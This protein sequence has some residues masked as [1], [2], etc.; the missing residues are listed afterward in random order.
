VSG[1]TRT[2]VRQRLAELR[3]ATDVGAVPEQGL[4]VAKLCRDWLARGLPGNLSENTR[5]QYRWA[6]ETHIVPALGAARVVNLTPQ[7]VD[8][9]LRTKAAAGKSRRTLTVLRMV[10]VRALRF[11]ERWGKVARNVAALV[12]IPDAPSK[13]GRSLTLEEAR[14]LLTAAASERL[15]A[16]WVTGLLVGLRPGE[17]LALGWDDVDLE[18]GTLQV[19]RALHRGADNRLYLGQVKTRT[20]RRALDLPAPVVEAMRAHRARQAVERLAAGAAWDDLGLV[21]CTE[22]GT[23]I[24]PSNLR[25]SLSKLTTRAGLGHWHPHEL[26]HSAASLLSAAGVPLED[27]ADL[28]GHSSPT[29]TAQVYRHPIRRTVAAGKLP[30]ERL[31]G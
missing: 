25:R 21:F 30:M 7:D 16:L 19:R 11:G 22:V 31:F 6:V 29:V 23:P 2:E 26:R 15:E 4:T 10:L 8:D 5:Y 18:A 1:R 20:S 24:D 13:L 28:L 27:I 3:K 14:S 9:F 17:L 12:E